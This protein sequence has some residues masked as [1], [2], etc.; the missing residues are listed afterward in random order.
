MTRAHFRL[1]PIAGSLLAAGLL[2]ATAGCADTPAWGGWSSAPTVAQI[3]VERGVQPDWVYYPAY[4]VYYS[5][6]YQEYIYW[7]AVDWVTRPAPILPLT[8]E[9]LQ[10]SPSVGLGFHDSPALHHA[11]VAKLYPRDWHASG[12]GFASARGY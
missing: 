8:P 9:K 12:N 5:S 3:Q 10:A 2:L 7:D 4:Q 11:A 1:V 6:N